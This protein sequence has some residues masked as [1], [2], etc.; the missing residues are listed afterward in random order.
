M[1]RTI[2]VIWLISLLGCSTPDPISVLTNRLNDE[3]GGLW[4]NGT[5]PIIHLPATATTTD[6]LN[7]A[8]KKTGFDEGHI[9]KYKILTTRTVSLRAGNT[10]EYCALLIDSDLG[11]KILLMRYEGE[12]TGWWTR[13]YN[14]KQ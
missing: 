8:I 5:Y 3:V 12:I 7:E 4:I 6:V 13:F 2:A 11:R 10:N 1:R 14:A 9:K